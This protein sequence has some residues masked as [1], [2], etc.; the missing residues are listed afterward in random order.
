VER[1]CGLREAENQAARAVLVLRA[2][3]DHLTGC[4]G[5]SDLLNRDLPQD[6][7]IGGMLGELAISHRL[8]VLMK[9]SL[10]RSSIVCR[11]GALSRASPPTDHRKLCVSR[12]ALT[13]PKR[14]MYSR[15]SSSGSSKSSDMVMSPF[16]LP[17]CRFAGAEMGMIF[18]TGSPPSVRITS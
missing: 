1:T 13:A 8:A 4:N 16:A 7:L 18:A 14:Y 6:A 11:V 15:K 9:A 12:R 10:S 2:I 17:N 3:L 5:F